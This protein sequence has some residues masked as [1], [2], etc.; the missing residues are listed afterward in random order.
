MIRPSD[1]GF[2]G[3]LPSHG[4]FLRRRA[5][6]A[7]VAAWDAWLQDC[8]AESRATLGERWLDVYLTSPAWR[9]AC[10]AGCCGSTPLVG[11]MV[12]SVDRV[13]RYFP[14]TAVAA[15]PADVD[16]LAAATSAAP[17]LDAVERLTI[18]TLEASEIDLDAVDA[19]LVALAALLMP[20]HQRPGVVLEPAAGAMLDDGGGAGVQFAI[21]STA[22]MGAALL[23]VL[24]HRLSAVYAPLTLWWTDGST[25]LDPSGLVCRGLPAP[26]AFAALLDGRWT[27]RRWRVAPSHVV[28]GTE[29]PASL[30]EADAPLAY[31]SA[32]ASHAGRIRPVN[33]DAFLERCDAGIWVVADG[34][35][36][37]ADGEIASR[38]VCDAFGDLG[39][40]SSFDDLVETA[41]ERM[42]QVN[43]HLV[44]AAVRSLDGV[45]CGS[46]V[47]AL[48]V[49]GT[50]VA[51]VWAGDSRVYRRRNGRLERLTRDHS[52]VEADSEEGV[53]GASNI[54]TRAVGGENVLELDVHR[55]RVHPGDRFLL[56]SDGLTR[57]V[58]DVRIGEWMAHADV[59][60]GV[61]GLVAASLDAGAPDNVTAV[62]V[63][64]LGPE[65]DF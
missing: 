14:F 46:T 2:Y 3:K 39:A 36:G 26:D 44:R 31:R 35:G 16:L 6:D 10:A 1:V 48:L 54:V 37:H 61:D 25:A 53:P 17:F 60:A 4:D 50:R 38:M 47:V 5:P 63:E 8:M 22:R 15:L 49:R 7:F 27:D 24:S 11:V 21:G 28:E 55:D 23:Q 18:E 42:H 30:A 65:R 33:Q 51:V 41:I 13:G 9:F 12:P 20:A 62:L 32:A 58:T 29:A 56:C 19:H 45:R 64:A 43:G 40:E 59:A 34:L 52:L 57:T